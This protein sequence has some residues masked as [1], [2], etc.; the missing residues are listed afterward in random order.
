MGAARS[1]S[2][3]RGFTGSLR[4]FQI[5]GWAYEP[6]RPGE[7]VRVEARLDGELLGTTTASQFAEHLLRAGIGGGDH[8]FVFNTDRL[9][10]VDAPDRVEVRALPENG[11]PIP[12][13]YAKATRA[14]SGRT[15]APEPNRLPEGGTLDFAMAD[16]TQRPVFVLGSARSGTSAM[17]QALNSATRYKGFGEGHLLDMLP[18]LLRAVREHYQHRAGKKRLP[19]L[20]AAVPQA[21]S[22][23]VI[24]QGFAQLMRG[25][26]PSGCWMDKTPGP[27]MTRA[28]PSLRQV[29][30]EARFIHMRRRGIENVNSRRR[31]FPGRSFREHC[32]DWIESVTAWESARPLLA[33]VALEVDQLVLARE[34]DR[35]VQVLAPFLSLDANEEGRLR[36]ALATDRPERTSP[37]FGRPLALAD[38]SWSTEERGLFHDVCGTVMQKLGYALTDDYF[39]PGGASLAV[40]RV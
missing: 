33:G 17:A 11:P 37:V 12:L 14:G 13:A 23:A 28:A 34:P 40:L 18:D 6:S 16:A 27:D 30:P 24:A 39:L 10:P 22:E 1:A 26:Y 32:D 29:W 4:P 15:H 21:Q 19:T 8:A 31:K 9:L 20:L 36:Q 2:L 25:L 38:L 5:R 35:V 3:I 7:H